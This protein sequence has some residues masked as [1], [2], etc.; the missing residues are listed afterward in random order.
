MSKLKKLGVLTAFVLCILIA[1]ML[2][3]W[4]WGQQPVP[5]GERLPESTWIG[6]EVEQMR[7][8]ESEDIKFD[9]VPMEDVLKQLQIL[10]VSHSKEARLPAEPHFRITLYKAD[11]W[12]AVLYITSE[13]Q[14]QL[15]SDMQLGTWE[16][17]EGAEPL[18]VYLSNLSQ[19][20]PVVQ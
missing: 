12:P 20:L 10:R 1:V 3:L 8:M 19:T 14:V 4:C 18:Y 5:L 15:C 7:P 13:G 6:I 2:C 9:Q 17:Y 11:A 16:Y